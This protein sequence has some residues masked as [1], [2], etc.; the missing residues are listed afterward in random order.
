MGAPQG[1]DDLLREVRAGFIAQGVTLSAWCSA[2]KVTR[3]YA[4]HV[5]RGHTNGPNALALRTRLVRA[6]TAV[7]A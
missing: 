3:S 1:S 2:N 7:A 4:H 6:A 5:L